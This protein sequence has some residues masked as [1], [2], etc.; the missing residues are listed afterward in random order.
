EEEEEAA[1][2]VHATHERLVSESDPKHARR[3]TRRRSSRNAFKD[4]SSVLKK[5]S[6][7]HS[8]KLKGIQTMTAEEQLAADTMQALKASKK[9]SG[10]ILTTSSE[11]TSTKPGVP[12]EVKGSSKDKE[13]EWL[14]SDEEEEKKDD[15]EDH[16]SIVIK[17]N[18]DDEE[19][20]DE[21]VHGDEYVQDD[22]DEEMKDAEDTETGKDDEDITDAENTDA[23]KIEINS[24]LD[25]QIQQE[26]P[27]IRSP[28]ILTIL[29]LVIPEPIVLSPIPKIPILTPATTPSPPL[30]LHY[31]TSTIIL[32]PLPAIAQRVSVLEKDVQELK[33]ADHSLAI[34]ATIRSQVSAAVD[35]YLRS[36]H[37]D[38]LQK[39]LQKHTEEHIQQSSQKYVYEIIKIKQ[40]QAAKEKMPKFLATPYDHMMDV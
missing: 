3:S 2:R 37:G 19:T 4:T 39:V 22:V 29:V 30:S 38:A 10:I 16:R 1:R 36:S 9:L 15:N 27:H 17:K 13:V 21:F 31:H 28:S 12:N 5:K 32:D 35:E 33:P 40:E 18:D 23:E 20:E 26:V 14:Y 34:L 8:Q 11:G 7:D 6:P 25:I 24:L